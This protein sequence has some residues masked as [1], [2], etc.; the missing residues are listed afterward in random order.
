MQS[1]FHRS[2]KVPGGKLLVV[3][4]ARREG[5]CWDWLVAGDFFCFPETALDGVARGLDGVDVGASLG[6]VLEMV[7]RSIPRDAELVG[8]TDEAIAES[9]MAL[10]SEARGG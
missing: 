6:V 5:R 1:R 7:R 3:E 8:V 4:C 9:V 2:V 10:L